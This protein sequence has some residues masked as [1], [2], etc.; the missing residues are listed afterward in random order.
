MSGAA[1]AC[2]DGPVSEL[3]AIKA[4]IQA[5][6]AFFVDW[7]TGTIRR[8]ETEFDAALTSRFAPDLVLI[9]PRGVTLEGDALLDGI[10]QA[11]DSNSDFRIAIRNVRIHRVMGEH[12]LATYEEW[13]RNAKASSPPNN[14]RVATV[15][16]SRDA[17]A[18]GGLRWLHVHETWLPADQM[19]AGPYDF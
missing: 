7:F 15:L 6:H 19:S 13:Q 17:N 11:Y 14:G 2:H 3:E 4:E 9:P 16:F 10:R 18:P 1:L 12:T 8:D 5:V